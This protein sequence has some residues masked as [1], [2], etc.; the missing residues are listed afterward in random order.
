MTKN[1]RPTYGTKSFNQEWSRYRH[2]NN[3]P[4]TLPKVLTGKDRKNVASRARTFIRYWTSSPFEHEANTVYALRTS[5]VLTGHP[6]GPSD[7]DARSIVGDA[8]KALGY[9]RPTW[10]EGQ[11]HYVID[12]EH[13]QW[14][15]RALPEDMIQPG[16]KGYCSDLC[17]RSSLE[18]R[19]FERRVRA[20]EAYDAAWAAIQ[21][22]KI[23]PKRCV[24]CAKPFRPLTPDASRRF[25]SKACQHAASRKHHERACATCGTKFRPRYASAQYCGRSCASEAQRKVVPTLQCQCCGHLFQP[26]RMPTK[27][28][29]APKY[30]SKACYHEAR[31]VRG[32]G[33]MTV[34][35]FD[36]LLSIAA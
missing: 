31:S 1:F 24:Q 6:W 29:P 30:C 8:F 5:L 28:R 26:E 27:Q 25:C 23:P 3:K 17:A 9:R 22:S 13:C 33:R 34:R 18:H 16:R 11:R 21:R 32:T 10:E 2:G 7:A 14:C 4:V 12:N 20:D 15:A 19:D 36:Q 35:L